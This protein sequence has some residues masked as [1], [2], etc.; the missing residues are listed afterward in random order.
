MS[1]PLVK[2]PLMEILTTAQGALTPA[3]I[4]D[5]LVARGIVAPGRQALLRR[6]QVLLDQQAIVQ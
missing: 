6:L 5:S 1:K 2:W 4:T 3:Q